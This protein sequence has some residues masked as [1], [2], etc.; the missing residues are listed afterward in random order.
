MS[1]Q[2]WD[3]PESLRVP[4]KNKKKWSH[5]SSVPVAKTARSDLENGTGFRYSFYAAKDHALFCG[6]CENF[7]VLP[8]CVKCRG[9]L[10]KAYHAALLQNGGAALVCTNCEAM[11]FAWR[12]PCGSVNE[13]NTSISQNFGGVGGAGC[14]LA[15]LVGFVLL[16][17]LT[18]R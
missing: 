9:G 16:F 12:C 13:V 15:L 3:I 17:I 14:C 6:D 11:L 2:V 8:V 5:L 10:V 7:F 4:D 1:D 18:M